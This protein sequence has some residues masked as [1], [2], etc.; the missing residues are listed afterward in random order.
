MNIDVRG[1]AASE[2]NI[3]RVME[4]RRPVSGEVLNHGYYENYKRLLLS[5]LSGAGYFEAKYL[6]N[7]VV[8]DEALEYADVEIIVDSGPRY[9]F[10][11]VQFSGNVLKH[12]L[13]EGYADF[14]EGEPYSSRDITRM[15]ESLNGSGFFNSVSIVAEPAADGSRTVPVKVTVSPAKPKVYSIGVGYA[16]D[17][18]LQ[19]RLG[20]TNRRIN[21]RGH[22]FRRTPV[23]FGSRI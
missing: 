3:E 9:F 7:Q 19:G 5:R 18:G 10:G 15:H 11:D 2:I 6:S 16:T 20:F 13:L 1:D 4:G 17:F 8:V 14:E 22:Q 12:E 21:D 23:C